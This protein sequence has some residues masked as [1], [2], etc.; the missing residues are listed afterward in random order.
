MMPAPSNSSEDT[1]PTIVRT[2]SSSTLDGSDGYVTIEPRDSKPKT[3]ASTGKPSTT[4]GNTCRSDTATRSQFN[5]PNDYVMPY[6]DSFYLGPMYM[7]INGEFRLQP[8]CLT[9]EQIIA[10]ETTGA[11]EKHII[12]RMEDMLKAESFCRENHLALEC[13]A[14]R[15][16]RRIDEVRQRDCKRLREAESHS[17]ETVAQCIERAR[18]YLE[19]NVVLFINDRKLPC[20]QCDQAFERLYQLKGSNIMIC[21]ECHDQ[22]HNDIT[23]LVQ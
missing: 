1:V 18:S 11:S 23:E 2:S 7:N 14:S 4:K 20:I 5:D 3:H 9:Q 15:I 17:K 6:F 19:W 8:S 12:K 22:H 10:A 13:L 16:D 21:Q